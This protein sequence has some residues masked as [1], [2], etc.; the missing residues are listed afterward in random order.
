MQHTEP[1]IVN[2]LGAQ[3]SIPRN[4]LRQPMEPGGA[5]QYEFYLSCRPPGGIDS[6]ERITGLLKRLQIRALYSRN[7]RISKMSVPMVVFALL[8]SSVAVLCTTLTIGQVLYTEE[9]SSTV[10]H[11][12]AQ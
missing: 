3:E 12:H 10:T 11:K 9:P 1:E 5:G 8:I 4:R 2:V 6:M 7:Q